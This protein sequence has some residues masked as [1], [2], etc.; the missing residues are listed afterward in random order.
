MIDANP[1]KLAFGAMKG[2]IVGIVFLLFWTI[3]GVHLGLW[4]ILI[5][6]G[7]ILFSILQFETS[8]TTKLPVSKIIG[9]GAMI[10]LS[11][12]LVNYLVTVDWQKVIDG[13]DDIYRPKL[14]KGIEG[15]TSEGEIVVRDGCYEISSGSS[16][17]KTVALNGANVKLYG[18]EADP[19]SSLSIEIKDLDGYGRSAFFK[20]SVNGNDVSFLESRNVCGDILNFKVNPIT[21]EFPEMNC[22]Q[23]SV[24]KRS[25][26][27]ALGNN[28]NGR[29]SYYASEL[30]KSLERD[31]E[32]NYKITLTN[33]GKSPIKIGRIEIVSG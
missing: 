13:G 26:S 30:P 1:I 19:S 32:V 8:L 31:K 22:I 24:K 4:G 16:M 15:W 20:F 17:L 23:G 5:F 25:I 9:I 6:L 3:S 28:E 29:I 33:N 2:L 11:I 10:I 18:I 27:Y 7:I 14:E 12:L 21:N